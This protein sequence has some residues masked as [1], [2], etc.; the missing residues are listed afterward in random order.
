VLVLEEHELGR[1]QRVKD[2]HQHQQLV[3][4]STRTPP[5]QRFMSNITDKWAKVKDKYCQKREIKEIIKT[6]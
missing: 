2:A 1:G 5:R 4:L 6:N 3:V